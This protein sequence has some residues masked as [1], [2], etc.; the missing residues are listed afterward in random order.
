MK[1]FIIIF[2]LLFCFSSKAQTIQSENIQI[3]RD[4]YGVPHIFGKTDADAA[5]GLAWAHSED[6]FKS[7]QE[8][9]LPSKGL[10]GS[11]LGKE[12]VLFDYLLKFASLDVTVPKL[13]K[14][15]ALSDTF[16]RVISGY[17][18]GLNAYAVAHPEQLL[19]K[20]LFP[21]SE[22]D[23]LNGYML[24]L[25][26]MAGVGMALK[27]TRENRIDMYSAPNEKGSNG[28]AVAKELM[29]DN[30]TL[31]VGNSHQ[32]I[33]G[34]FAWYEAHIQSEEGWNI[35][36]GLFPGGMTIF[37][38]NNENLGWTHTVNYHNFGDIY[39][40]KTKGK[41]YFLDGE[42]KKFKIRKEKFKL[43]VGFF[44]IGITKKLYDTEFG[45]VFST[46]HG[47]YAFRFPVYMDIRA[48]EQWYKMNKSRN[49]N[50][51]ESALKMEALPLFN[52]VYA[53]KENN[54]M[55]QSGGQIPLRDPKLDWKQPIDGTSSKAK[56]NKLLEYDKKPIVLNPECGYVF[57]ANNTPL[58]CTG[59]NCEWNEYFVGL[60]MFTMNRAE[61]FD[62]YFESHKGKFTDEDIH[63][64]KYNKSFLKDASYYN[65]FKALY[66]L[67]ENKYPRLKEAIQT[68]KCWDF[69]ADAADTNASIVLVVHK[70]LA[71]K[72][73]GSVGFLSIQKESLSESDVVWA[74]TKAKHFLMKTHH[75]IHP[76]LG[77]V[78]RHIRGDISYPVGGMSE[79]PKASESSLYDEK[80]GIYRLNGG[81]GYI[82]FAKFS[83]KGVEIR[84]I[85]AF[86]AS[87]MKNSPHYT[88]QMELFIQEKT[89]PMTLNK[90]EIF[91]DAVRIYH[92]K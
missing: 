68:V 71:K 41:S 54:I 64:V 47:K 55:L 74:L 83:D 19:H 6:D 76:A 81:D 40:L 60:Q 50:E 9:L 26:L 85:N 37:V 44:K 17:V 87:S 73:Q 61:L 91:R 79:V 29:D 69:D 15:G 16:E 35:T 78:Q 77:D 34:G 12:G 25:S 92:P 63:F 45:P 90:A 18:Q 24:K 67:D 70:M 5:Y 27:A 43:K 89:K 32:P 80:K 30:K 22:V 48:A 82:H 36:G 42:W 28:I 59:E 66:N 62:R 10:A 75:S 3:V 23:I 31:L 7:I 21:I 46:K 56:W 4:A 65:C 57:N 53:D 52:V 13:Y 58:Q 51:F 1:P 72:L 8:N 33:E 20:D 88:D 38:G 84:T 14:Q 86:G 2:F 11:V 49:W 39:K